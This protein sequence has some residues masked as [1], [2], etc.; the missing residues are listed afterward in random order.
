MIDGFFEILKYCYV[1]A[2]FLF[3]VIDVLVSLALIALFY[4]EIA[5]KYKWRQLW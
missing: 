2:F 1:I 3:L 4:N 5:K